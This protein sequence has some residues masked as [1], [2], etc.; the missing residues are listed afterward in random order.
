M[1]VLQVTNIYPSEATPVKGVFVKEQIDSIARAVDRCDV[2]VIPSQTRGFRAYFESVRSVSKLKRDYDVVHAHHV[3]SGLTCIAAGCG[4]KQ[5]TSFM[6]DYGRNVLKVPRWVSVLLERIC[7]FVSKKAVFKTVPPFKLDGRKDILLPNGVDF[8][9]FKP[10][11]RS[12]VRESLGVDASQLALLF[13]SANDLHRPA[14]RYDLFRDV[15]SRLTELGH[16]VKELTMVRASRE[17]TLKLYNAADFLV[18]TS[19]FEGSPNAVK[20]ALATGLRVVSRSVGDVGILLK[21]VP[22]CKAVDTD[23]SDEIAFEV[24]RLAREA[25]EPTEV[26]AAFKSKGYGQEDVAKALVSA[27][28][29]VGALVRR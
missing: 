9:F 18:V 12:A 27:Y 1:K 15:V 17:E 10:L 14:K 24:D 25:W 5:V 20:E 19:D 13:V 4:A 23:R 6:N 2:F 28:E 8:G 16:D 11:E 21:D 22:S 26:R 29:E 3:L 7:Y